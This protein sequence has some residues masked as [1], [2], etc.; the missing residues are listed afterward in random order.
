[1]SDVRNVI[2]AATEHLLADR[3]LD[4]LTVVDIIEEAGVSR[5]TFYIYFESKHAAVAAVAEAVLNAAYEELWA[6]WFAG[7]EPMIHSSFVDHMRQ[8]I[9]LWR[10]HRAVMV[11]AAQGWRTN[12]DVYHQ[13]GEIW[14]R[15]V[16]DIRD[17]IELVG[18]AGLAPS[19]L[20]AGALAAALTW[21]NESALYLAATGEAPELADDD[22]L[23]TTLASV[24]WTAIHGA[25]D[26]DPVA[27]GLAS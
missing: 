23:A 13:W 5:A 20:E 19:G 3:P 21:M 16:A 15:Y 22:L 12:P 7:A 10:E 2:L 26:A 1:M 25:G 18:E 17:Y 6:P 11:A 24:W 4:E 27:D 9:N 14:K 8:G